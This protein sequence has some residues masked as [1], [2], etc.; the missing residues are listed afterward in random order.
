MKDPKLLKR[1]FELSLTYGHR[2]ISQILKQEGIQISRSVIDRL[3]R[4]SYPDD[5][6]PKTLQEESR[7]ARQSRKNR[8]LSE[9]K[10]ESPFWYEKFKEARLNAIKAVNENKRLKKQNEKL[11]AEIKRLKEVI[12]EL[13]RIKSVEP[14]WQEYEDYGECE[15]YGNQEYEKYW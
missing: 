8:P 7:K 10:I 3:L 15:Q 12:R 5:I 14:N 11:R 4:Q 9:K 13:N 6:V 1:I 2:R